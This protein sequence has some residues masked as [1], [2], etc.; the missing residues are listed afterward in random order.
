VP[1]QNRP[2]SV[3]R[4]ED[5]ARRIAYERQHRG[6]SYAGLASRMT[7]RG[8]AIDSS[9]LYK[10]E[11]SK[12]RR[13]ITVDE[14]VALSNVFGISMHDFLAPPE[15]AADKRAAKLLEEF[16]SAQAALSEAALDLAIHAADHPRVAPFLEAEL[17]GDDLLQIF[18]VAKQ[19]FLQN[20]D[21]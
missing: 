12:P 6:W 5:L 15:V 18:H 3:G 11:N 10:I 21:N 17:T 16:R 19:Q 9:A 7:E 13:R 4:E 20:R 1:R 8:C 2:R 14:L